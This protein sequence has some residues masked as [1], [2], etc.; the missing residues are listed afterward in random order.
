MKYSKN[1]NRTNKRDGESWQEFDIMV[2]YISKSRTVPT[3]NQVVALT[4]TA[5]QTIIGGAYH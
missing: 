3:S 2:V 5:N 4:S 1:I